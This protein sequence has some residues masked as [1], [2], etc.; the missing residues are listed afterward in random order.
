MGLHYRE[1][2]QEVFLERVTAR[3]AEAGFDSLLDYYYFLKYD[4]AAARELEMLVDALVINETFFFRELEPLRVLVEQ[5]IAPLVR[6]GKKVRVWSAAC[7]TGEEPLTLAMLLAEA[8]L[9]SH[10][11]IIASDIS[12]RAL[13]RARA[14][15]YG[16]R[17]LRDA[18]HHGM[19]ARWIREVDGTLVVDESIRSAITWKRVNLCSRESVN[20]VGSNH[21]ILCRN[22]LIYFDDATTVRVLEALGTALEP[23]GRLLVGVSESLLRFATAL[24]CEEIQHAFFYRKPHDHR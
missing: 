15:K 5:V 10:V 7:S 17:S 19:A 16:K 18:E 1:D 11:E 23:G 6:A 20:S 21:F 14:G 4:A 24:E 22:A 13:D 8:K 3:A 12:V 9:L 2:D